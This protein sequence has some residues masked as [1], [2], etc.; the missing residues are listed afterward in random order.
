MLQHNFSQFYFGKDSYFPWDLAH[1]QRY[2]LRLHSIAQ[3]SRKVSIYH[4]FIKIS[5]H[6]SL[7]QV[8]FKHFVVL[9]LD[10]HLI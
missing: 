9:T 4:S 1:Q 5:K 10:L 2:I 8:I 6:A 7:V 3:S